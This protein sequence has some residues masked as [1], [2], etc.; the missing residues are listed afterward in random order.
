MAVGAREAIQES[1]ELPAIYQELESL[2]GPET[3]LEL[4]RH[5]GGTYQYFPKFDRIE[6][7]LRN[8]QIRAAFNGRNHLELARRY[9]LTTRQVRE[10][11]RY[12]GR[13][14]A[15]A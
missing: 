11:V 14:E 8:R 12:T 1:E 3:A 2:V 5:F 10:I 7:I 6:M 9:N 15:A 13:G 4:A